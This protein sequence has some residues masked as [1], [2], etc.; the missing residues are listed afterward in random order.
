MAS[1]AERGPVHLHSWPLAHSSCSTDGGGGRTWTGSTGTRGA[2]PTAPIS[3]SRRAAAARRA[4]SPPGLPTSWT[5]SGV[6]SRAVPTGTLIAGRLARDT[7]VQG[8]I[9][10]T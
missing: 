2:P 3:A 1:S 6:P 4:A 7:T 9:H 5:P 8:S 10:S